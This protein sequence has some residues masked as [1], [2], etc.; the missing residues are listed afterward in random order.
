MLA[1]AE[2][3]ALN[4]A[5]GDALAELRTLCQALEGTDGTANVKLDLS[6]VNDMEYYNGLVLQGYLAGLPRAVLKGRPVR[7]LAAQFRPGAR[8]IG[9]ALYLDELDRPDTPAEP[10]RPSC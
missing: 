10:G 4:A 2:P 3:L 1:A 6:L 5:M 9:F 7:P 8:A